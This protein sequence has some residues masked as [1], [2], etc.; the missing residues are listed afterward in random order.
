MNNNQYIKFQNNLLIL[1]T[2]RPLAVSGLANWAVFANF[3]YDDGKTPM[4]TDYLEV[5]GNVG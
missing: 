2:V 5:S 3:N 4:T 1:V